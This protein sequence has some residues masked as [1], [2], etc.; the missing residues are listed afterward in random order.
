MPRQIYFRQTVSNLLVPNSVGSEISHI[1]VEKSRKNKTFPN[2]KMVDESYVENKQAV[3]DLMHITSTLVQRQQAAERE[4]AAQMQAA[5]RN[6]K[7]HR[8][9]QLLRNRELLRDRGL[10]RPRAAT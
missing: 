3:D 5:A 1:K 9:R 10:Q 8:C 6:R 4:R 7:M 2:P